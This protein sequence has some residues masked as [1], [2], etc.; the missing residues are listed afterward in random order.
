M[1]L[2]HHYDGT[3]EVHG[4]IPIE[5]ALKSQTAIKVGHAACISLAHTSGPAF[6]FAKW[7]THA[8]WGSG[9]CRPRP[10]LSGDL[11]LGAST[12]PMKKTKMPLESPWLVEKGGEMVRRAEYGP[13]PR[14]TGCNDQGH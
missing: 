1:R 13:F 2:P 8:Q 5:C 14:N 6:N 4:A 9:R 3:T 10:V 7:A 11:G 12:S